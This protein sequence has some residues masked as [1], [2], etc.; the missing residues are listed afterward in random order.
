MQFPEISLLQVKAFCM[1]LFI[2]DKL[3]ERCTAVAISLI[4]GAGIGATTAAIIGWNVTLCAA[5]GAC[6]YVTT[7]IAFR[8]LLAPLVDKLA[9]FHLLVLER[10]IQAGLTEEDKF[11]SV[12]LKANRGDVEF[13]LMAAL[14]FKAGQGVEKNLNEA[15]KY[16][17]MVLNNEKVPPQQK[18]NVHYYL[19]ELYA[20]CEP[21]QH[22]LAIQHL[23]IAD[24]D[25]AKSYLCAMY[26]AGIRIENNKELTLKYTTIVEKEGIANY[27]HWLRLAEQNNEKGAE[28]AALKYLVMA[29]TYGHSDAKC[30]IRDLYS[31]GIKITN[32]EL[33]IDYLKVVVNY[34]KNERFLGDRAFYD[35][36]MIYK[37]EGNHVEAVKW[38]K[39]AE[40]TN[41][42]A[43][44]CLGEAYA[45]GLGVEQNNKIALEYLRKASEKE[46]RGQVYLSEVQKEI[47]NNTVPANDSLLTMPFDKAVAEIDE[48]FN[49]Q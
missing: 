11:K 15:I 45:H 23:I 21:P 1:K 48:A 44:R 3:S 40:K 8:I 27:N 17:T 6:I 42:N 20:K 13:Q 2:A 14:S 39:L 16:F 49:G 46:K 34:C 25:D 26:A 10:Q 32:R 33:N 18:V 47:G 36:G 31:G 4:L 29:G 37:N 35:L 38:F 5:A 24:S 41:V 12:L 7:V 43:Q 9:R 30:R 22:E 28:E 19:G